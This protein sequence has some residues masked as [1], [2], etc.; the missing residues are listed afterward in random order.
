VRVLFVQHQDDCPP[1][2]VGERLAMLGATVEVVEARAPRLPD[3]AEFDLIVPLGS[4]DSAADESLSYL[5]SEWVLI[6]RAVQSGVPVFGICF[7]AQLLCRVL[8]GSVR[9]ATG[10]PEIGWLPM[11]TSD[12]EV[13]EPGPW[14]VWHLDVMEPGPGSV[15]VARTAVSAQAFAHGRHLGVQFHPEATVASVRVWAEHYR[16]SLDQLGIEP[17]ALLEETQCRAREARLRAHTLVDRV[18]AR[19]GVAV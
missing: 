16:N 8:G 7:G 3:P 12:T 15:A 17:T 13:V 4:D 19:A 9:P 1:A 2:L 11:L 6:E 5:R 18:L 14:L 10:G